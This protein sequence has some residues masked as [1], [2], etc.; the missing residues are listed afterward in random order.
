VS[1]VDVEL[2]TSLDVD[3]IVRPGQDH[4]RRLA[5]VMLTVVHSP[6]YGSQYILE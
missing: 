2:L 3:G 1:I 5:T 4:H 6:I